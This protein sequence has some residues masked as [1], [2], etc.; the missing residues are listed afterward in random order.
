M[1]RAFRDAL[2]R[3]R[4]DVLVYSSLAG[5]RL[6]FI[7]TRKYTEGQTVE[8]TLRLEAITADGAIL[9]YQGERFLLPPP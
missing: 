1:P 6:V 7:N 8:G 9:S 5:D 2:P 3:L 4:L